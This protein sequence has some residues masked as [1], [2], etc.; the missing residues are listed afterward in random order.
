MK[1]KVGE[2]GLV[3]EAEISYRD[4]SSD[5]PADWITR[6]MK[7]PVRNMVKLFQLV[8]TSMMDD[9]KDVHECVKKILDEKKILYVPL[10]N[11]SNPANTVEPKKT[12]K[13][14]GNYEDSEELEENNELDN[15]IE[16]AEEEEH[17]APIPQVKQKVPGRRRKTKLE[18][19]EIEMKNWNSCKV[20]E[21]V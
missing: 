4:V 19:L 16:V 21:K 9:I 15:Q 20:Q 14:Q 3:R 1:V 17:L 8:D 5:E 2:D 7:R 6:T 11:D 10:D 12:E 13:I 18:N